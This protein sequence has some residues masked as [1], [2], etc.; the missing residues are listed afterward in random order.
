[1]RRAYE[2]IR[3][4]EKGGLF[5]PPPLPNSSKPK[6]FK[7]Y[8]D[9]LEYDDG[10]CPT[11]NQGF[12]CGALL[13]AKELGLG[14]TDD[15][16]DRAV[17]GFQSL[18]NE[19]RGF[20]PTSK[21]QPDILGQDTLYGAAMTYAVF[22]RKVATDDQVKRH[23]RHTFRVM[24]AHGMRVISNADGSLLD[25]HGGAYVWGGSWFMCD[26]A[27]LQ[28]GQIHG[29]K[30]EEMDRRL[31]ERI[32]AEVKHYPAFSGSINT[33]T[34]RPHGHI[35]YSSHSGYAWMRPEIRK[36]LGLD[37]PDAVA[38]AVDKR[39]GVVNDKMANEK[40]WL[41]LSGT[42]GEERK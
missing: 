22:G 31:V 6:G 11:S 24:P 1:M 40:G 39:L 38:E 42:M 14:A 26:H 41:R 19:R 9:L 7:T 25:G 8:M 2:F 33:V 15:D 32:M 37:G 13:A 30:A 29:M 34:G 28:L 36:R 35:L 20:F 17:A 21:M 18:F 4:N 27:N 16:I 10:D 23:L 12:H 5:I 3:E